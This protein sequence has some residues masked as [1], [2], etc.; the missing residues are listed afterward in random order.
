MSWVSQISTPASSLGICSFGFSQQK[1]PPWM[2]DLSSDADAV[3]PLNEGSCWVV[4]LSRGVLETCFVCTWLYFYLLDVCICVYVSVS[5]EWLVCFLAY[6]HRGLTHKTRLMMYYSFYPWQQFRHFTSFYLLFY[7]LPDLS[8]MSELNIHTIFFYKPEEGYLR[9]GALTSL[10][11]R[12]VWQT[13]K[14]YVCLRIFS[15]NHMKVFNVCLNSKCI[16]CCL[17]WKAIFHLA[18]GTFLLM[19]LQPRSD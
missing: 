7:F 12:T 5:G 6:T 4:R 2:S 10:Y 18:A 13:G 3:R 1:N 17:V 15:K 11:P 19:F 16:R 14:T 8:Q 9:P